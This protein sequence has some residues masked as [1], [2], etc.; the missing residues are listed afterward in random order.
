MRRA[1]LLL[2]ATVL[3]AVALRLLLRAGLPSRADYTAFLLN[4]DGSLTAPEIA[5]YAPPFTVQ[6][7]EGDTVTLT[8]FRGRAVVVNFWATWC[9]PC[10]VEMPELQT[11]AEVYPQVVVLGVNAGDPVPLVEAWSS[12]F[13]LTFPLLLDTDGQTAARYFLRGLPSTFVIA[14]DGIIAHIYYGPVDA[15]MLH[16]ALSPYLPR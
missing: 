15:E 6:T 10:A 13:G 7:L 1:L 2:T 9:A 3:A 5:A 12:R 16:S 11:L 4:T 14:P 8:D